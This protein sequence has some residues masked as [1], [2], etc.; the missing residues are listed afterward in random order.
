LSVAEVMKACQP[1]RPGKE[2]PQE[3]DALARSIALIDERI[4]G[5]FQDLTVA[6]CL[7]P[8]KS[9]GRRKKPAD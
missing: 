9:N 6:Q 3:A 5:P 1:D 4:H 2:K 8:H 7:A